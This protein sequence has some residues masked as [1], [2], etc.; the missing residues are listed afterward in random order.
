MSIAV[1]I[2]GIKEDKGLLAAVQNGA[3]YVGFL[4][5]EPGRRCYVTP[6]QVAPLFT[7]IPEHVASVGLFLDSTDDE[8]LAVTNAIPSL[9]ILQLHGHETPQRI[10]EIKKLTGKKVIK[11]FHVAARG[12]LAIVSTYNDIA[13]MFLFDT[14]TGETPT[15]GTGQCFDWTILKGQTFARPWMLAGGLKKENIQEAILTSG[16]TIV[17]LSS[18]VETNGQKDPVKIQAFLKLARNYL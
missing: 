1:K 17:D 16:A 18:G 4:F 6:A 3:A 9:S 8:I 15:G 2:C 10:A 7:L 14:K 13:D 12:D 5:C 11:V